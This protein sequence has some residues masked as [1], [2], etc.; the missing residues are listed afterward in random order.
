[1][2]SIREGEGR[3]WEVGV[4]LR[5]FLRLDKGCYLSSDWKHHREKRGVLIRRFRVFLPQPWNLLVMAEESM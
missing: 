1:M 4:L 2:L 3:A 5:D